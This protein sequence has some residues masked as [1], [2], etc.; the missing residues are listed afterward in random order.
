M[1]TTNLPDILLNV[2]NEHSNRLQ[3]GGCSRLVSTTFQKKYIIKFSFIIT[4][5]SA[6]VVP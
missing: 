5:L 6:N 3:H 4:M 1:L 2:K